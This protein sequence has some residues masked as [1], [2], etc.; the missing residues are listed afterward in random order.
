[1]K[2]VTSAKVLLAGSSL[3]AMGVA[4]SLPRAVQAQTTISSDTVISGSTS[5]SFVVTGGANITVTNTGT[6]HTAT[7]SVVALSV[8]SVGSVGTLSNSGTLWAQST[9]YAIQNLGTIGTLSNNGLIRGGNDPAVQNENIIGLVTITSIGAIIGR[10][11]LYNAAGASI[12]AIINDGTL[13]NDGSSGPAISNAGVIDTIV[14]N[15]GGQ[16]LNQTAAAIRN[17]GTIGSL[18]NAGTISAYYT[19][20]NNVG[21]AINLLTNSGSIAASSA[22]IN[23]GSVGTLIN[24][25]LINAGSAIAAS[26]GTVINSGTIAGDITNNSNVALTIIGGS[27]AT[28]G[29]L[30][31]AMGGWSSNPIVTLDSIGTIHNTNS[32]LVFS[33]G[34]LVLGDSVD[35]TGHTV[36]NTGAALTLTQAVT[37]TGAYGQSAGTLALTG[38]Q[39]VVTDGATIAGTVAATLSATGNY[40]A[41]SGVTLVSSPSAS[42]YSAVVARITTVSNVAG[43]GFSVGGGSL[44]LTVTNDYVGGSLGTIDNTGTISGVATGVYIAPTGTVGTLTNSG[45]ISGSVRGFA[46]DDTLIGSQVGGSV[47]TLSNAGT[48]SG[49]S[50]GVYMADGSRI[51]RIVNS[52]VILGTTSAGMGLFGSVG[53]LVNSVTGTIV[54]TNSTALGVGGQGLGQLTNNGLISGAVGGIAVLTSLSQ[55]I[56]AG[57]VTGATAL[58]VASSATLGPVANS[59]LIAGK[60]L[61]ASTNALT[62]SGGTGATIGTLTGQTVTSTGSIVNTLSNLSFT[63][64]NLLLNDD[65]NVTGHTVVNSGASLT[66]TNPVTVTGAFDQTAGTLNLTPG[67]SGLIV[68]GTVS[69]TGGSVVASVSSTSTYLAGASTL[70]SAGSALQ[71]GAALVTGTITGLDSGLSISGNNLLFVANNDYVGGALAT[72]ST[73]GSIGGVSQALYV[74]S[75]GTVGTLSNS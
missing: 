45:T 66:L 64:G 6:V 32:D 29:T 26:I 25:G 7:A 30:K 24:T 11:G 75:T 17:L 33:G 13:T 39:L 72:L 47:G 31:G 61:N 67:T 57:T 68:S 42:D 5:A 27:G 19:A 22:A 9:A 23:G 54:S 65:I 48:L 41:G 53:T 10:T 73:G 20:I 43:A 21:G 52:G 70:I 28:V 18:N 62:I 4:L 3:L 34:N 58:F 36:L 74:A 63:S 35:A 44:L 60:I 1:M 8:S 55:V 12:G 51:D 2:R 46:M 69:L 40:L 14:N 50:M 49:G 15:G 16:I 71:G 56:N 38:G 59:G 37:V